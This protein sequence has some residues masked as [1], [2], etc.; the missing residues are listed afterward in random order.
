MLSVVIPTLNAEADL[1]ACLDRLQGADEI[2]V[3]D[4]GSTD[5]T[6]AIAERAGA[7]LIVAPSG[8]G[9]QLKAGAEAAK[10]DWL[11]FLHADTVPGRRWREAVA[12][13]Q[14]RSS[15]RAACFR[16]RLADKAWQA[17]AIER[18]V[19]AR[20]ALLSM[21]Y[22]D[23]GLLISRRLYREV[24]GFRDLPLMED[25]DL[26]RRLG[27][28]RLALLDEDAFTSPDRWRRDGWFRRSARNLVCVTLYRLGVAPERIVR[29]YA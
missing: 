3:V 18:A 1:P 13:H 4:G 21:P 8:R 19:A 16:F 29:L 2:V 24:G 14:R 23:Q 27:R 12:T 28:R 7:R 6:A 22:G 5:A 17:R 9:T 15:A 11:L 25:V 20:V 10:G 26:A